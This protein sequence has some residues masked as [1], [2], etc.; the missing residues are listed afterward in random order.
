MSAAPKPGDE[1]IAA[2]LEERLRQIEAL[3]AKSAGPVWGAVQ[4]ALMRAKV[5]KKEVLRI[6]ATRDARGLAR[7][8]AALRGMTVAEAPEKGEAAP[9][10]DRAEAPS[11]GAP[12]ASVSPDEMKKAMRAFRR[13]IKLVRLDHESR[14]GVGPM[15][16]GHKADFDAILPPREFPPEVWAAL[17]AA[18]QLRDAGQGFLMLAE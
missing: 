2:D 8:V 5:D 14:L 1:A 10:D 12:P 3:D 17:V 9:G 18:G 11:A 13:R 16:G 4:H 7:L 6:V 15:T